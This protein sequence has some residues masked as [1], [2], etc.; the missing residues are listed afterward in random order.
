MY[1]YI[2]IY[3]DIEMVL[4]IMY[5]GRPCSIFQLVYVA[6]SPD[7]AASANRT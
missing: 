4:N 6:A 3:M 5:L 2:F 1:I 7:C